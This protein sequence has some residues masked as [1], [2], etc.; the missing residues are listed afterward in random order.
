MIVTVMTAKDTF[1]RALTK[2]QMNMDFLSFIALRGKCEETE[3]HRGR[4]AVHAHTA[5][6][7][8][9]QN[10]NQHH[11]ASITR[12]KTLSLCLAQSRCSV[13]TPFHLPLPLPFVSYSAVPANI[14]AGGNNCVVLFHLWLSCSREA[15]PS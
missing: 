6:K 11:A 8:K 1:F 15:A 2:S 4:G 14:R 10:H 9:M 5:T 13:L 12:P 3:V 7:W